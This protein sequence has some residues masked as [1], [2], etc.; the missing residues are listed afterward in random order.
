MKRYRKTLLFL[1]VALT[2]VL[3]S[4][5]GNDMDGAEMEAQ[6]YCKMVYAGHWPDFNN[7]YIQFC[8]G[9]NWNGR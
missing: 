4:I 6:R 5:F 3:A 1:G 2:L 7:N 9:P 8:D